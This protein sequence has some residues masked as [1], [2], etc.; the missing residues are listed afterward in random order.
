MRS[1]LQG[2]S[3]VAESVQI[4][5]VNVAGRVGHRVGPG[6]GRRRRGPAPRGYRA[7]RPEKATWTVSKRM[8]RS[9]QGERCET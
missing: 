7:P 1:P 3:S 5:L 8:A 2:H 4:G 6:A 9:N